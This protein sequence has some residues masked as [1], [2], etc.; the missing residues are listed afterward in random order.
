M[1]RTA[2]WPTLPAALTPMRPSSPARN[3]AYEPPRNVTASASASGDI[4]STR[5]S[6]CDSHGRSLGFDGASVNPQLPMSTVVTPCHDDG[7]AVGSQCS[8][9]S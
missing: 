4:P 3:S 7:D 2:Q 6:I 5:L 9:A 8:C 1:R